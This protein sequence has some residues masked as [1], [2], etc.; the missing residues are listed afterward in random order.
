MP[1]ASPRPEPSQQLHHI[2]R[3]PPPLTLGR[4]H[5]GHHPHRFHHH[6]AGLGPHG[7]RQGLPGK[8]SFKGAP[9]GLAATPCVAATHRSLHAAAVPA[10]HAIPCHASHMLPLA[11]AAGQAG[12]ALDSIRWGSDYLLKV[13]WLAAGP[14]RNV[15]LVAGQRCGRQGCLQ[16]YPKTHANSTPTGPHSARAPP[17][18]GAQGAARVKH[19]P[20]GHPG[21]PSVGRR[22]EGVQW[23]AHEACLMHTT[24]PQQA[25]KASQSCSPAPPPLA[26]TSIQH[27]HPFL[28]IPSL[29][30]PSGGRH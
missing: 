24:P 5:Q 3:V 19:V 29:F 12:A 15:Q 30:P 18:T 21:A 20:A 6:A 14:P 16:A 11:Q 17:P 26:S 8:R 25:W 10:A 4:Q 23:A 9:V 28:F 22:G 27:S 13:S 1:C 2:N 7:I